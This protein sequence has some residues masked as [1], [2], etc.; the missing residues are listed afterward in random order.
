MIGRADRPRSR[1]CRERRAAA[2]RGAHRQPLLSASRI[3][4]TSGEPRLGLDPAQRRRHRRAARR[5]RRAVDRAGGRRASS[6][7]SRSAY[8]VFRTGRA[9]NFLLAVFGVIYSIPSL[10][11]FVVMPVILGTSILNPV[12]IAA[13]L[14][15]YSVA[16][17]VRSVVDG[18]R[19]V[20]DVGEAVRHRRRLRVVAPA[21]P[22]RAAA[23]HAGDLRRPAG[24][25]RLQ[26]RAGQRGSGDRQRRARP[27]VRPRPEQRVPAPRSSSGLVLSLL[28][29]LVADATDPADPARSP[30]LG[31]GTAGPA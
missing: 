22:G 21:G 15:I 23:G 20:P 30:A 1:R 19:S 5:A 8:L 12:N 28:L 29:A 17:L 3:G 10:A 31:A 24:G 25:H 4:T 11:L 14:T 6:S 26:H 18:L 13:A 7:R 27:A 9:A 2:D 16:L